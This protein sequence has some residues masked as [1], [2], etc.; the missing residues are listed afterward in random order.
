MNSAA[1][2][3]AR[4]SKQKENCLILIRTILV[5]VLAAVERSLKNHPRG[6][7]GLAVWHWKP[8]RRFSHPPLAHANK[9]KI[10]KSGISTSAINGFRRLTA[11]PDWGMPAWI[12]KNRGRAVTNAIRFEPVACSGGGDHVR[13][14]RPCTQGW[15]RQGGRRPTSN[16]RPSGRLKRERRHTLNRSEF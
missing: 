16:A 6:V 14:S 1:L 13:N 12:L 5:R 11:V 15:P 9:Y 8:T 3:T 4:Q 2:Q 7:Q 10:Y